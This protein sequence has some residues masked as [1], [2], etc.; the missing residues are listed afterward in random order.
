MVINIT[1]LSFKPLTLLIKKF[2][3]DTEE[4]LLESDEDIKHA[5]SETHEAGHIDEEEK[6]LLNNALDM[7]E[8]SVKQIMVPVEDVITINSN[9][10]KKNILDTI[11][12]AN[13]TR[14]PII[15]KGGI[16][17]GALNASFIMKDLLKN[18]EFNLKNSSFDVSFFNK[19]EK[20]DDVLKVLRSNRQ[21]LGIV[22]NK[23]SST[24]MIGIVTI[25]DILEE[26]VGELYDETDRED[27]GILSIE[28]N[29][30][31]VY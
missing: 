19:D 29:H 20:L 31:I 2:I 3:K 10:N 5:L 27:D 11:L 26:L 12:N 30:F 23:D 1:V 22:V 6:E 18:E 9:A 8:I 15:N 7:D 21:S 16:V 17:T 28:E 4:T 14:Y 13:F 24:K 25:E